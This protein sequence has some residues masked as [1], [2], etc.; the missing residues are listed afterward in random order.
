MK[1]LP[2]ARSNNLVVKTVGKEILI[3]DL[4]IDRVVCLN[5]TAALVYLNCDGKTFTDDFKYENNLSDEIILLAIDQLFENKLLKPK[6]VP[7]EF[8]KGNNRRELIKRVTL[9][10]ALLLP[11]VLT[12]IAPTAAHAASNNVT[13]STP[14][15]TVCTTVAQCASGETCQNNCCTPPAGQPID[16]GGSTS[17]GGTGPGGCQ[18]IFGC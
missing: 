16:G 18:N 17:G 12:A 1:T 6:T 4:N 9:S 8:S 13:C 14:G 11:T 7:K 2:L 3:Y 5:P 15:Q 10:S